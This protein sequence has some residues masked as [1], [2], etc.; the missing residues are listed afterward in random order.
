MNKPQWLNIV[1]IIQAIGITCLGLFFVI[2]L[3]TYILFTGGLVSIF[4][5]IAEWVI[6]TNMNK[7]K[8][9]TIPLVAFFLKLVLILAIVFR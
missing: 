4:A 6:A 5:S 3:P 2:N 9:S 7:F 1:K 8:I